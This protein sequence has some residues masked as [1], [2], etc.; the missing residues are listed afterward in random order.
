MNVAV[1]GAGFC[2]LA[3]AFY[4][5]ERGFNVTVF[6]PKGV[7]GGASGVA[8]GLL[9]PYPGEKARLSELG[10]EAFAEAKKLLTMCG[11]DVFQQEGIDRYPV[12][13]EQKRL[14][15]ERACEDE[16]LV[17]DGEKLTFTDGI[18]VFAR[19]YLQ[20]LK[21]LSGVE[22]VPET[23]EEE[24]FGT[25]DAVVLAVGAR[26]HSF[27]MCQTLPLRFIKGQV[28]RCVRPEWLKRSLVAKGYIACT[29]NPNECI[30]G[31]TYEHNFTSEEVDI[32]EAKAQIL[33]RIARFLPFQT[34]F[35]VLG[36]EA[37]VRVANMHHYRPLIEE[38]ANKVYVL[39]GMGSRGL[40]YH[41]MYARRVAHLL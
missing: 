11:N 3:V 9:H 27:S 39:T 18:T 16:T 19:P 31:S 12:S 13:E 26:I 20:A 15:S 36:C 35:D 22:V 21:E 28:L 1:L 2:G 25:F 14:F 30:V 37:G 5:K 38:V 8:S 33:P 32:D 34:E 24:K 23:L 6:D 7:G 40:L 10:H 29:Q 41:A 17:F 4:A